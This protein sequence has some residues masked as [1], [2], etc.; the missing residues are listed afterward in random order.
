VLKK[1]IKKLLVLLML[2][3]SGGCGLTVKLNGFQEIATRHPVGMEQITENPESSALVKDLGF[4]I[5]ELER[6]LE[7]QR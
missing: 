2:L 3:V 1:R 4:Y 5:N 7:S 6:R